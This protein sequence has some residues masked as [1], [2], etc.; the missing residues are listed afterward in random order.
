MVEERKQKPI[1]SERLVRRSP[2]EPAGISRPIT[3]RKTVV[4]EL[5][6]LLFGTRLPADRIWPHGHR[7]C[8]HLLLNTSLLE[9]PSC[10][11]FSEAVPSVGLSEPFPAM[12]GVRLRTLEAH[13][14][15]GTAVCDVAHRVPS[16]ISF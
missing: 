7:A 12:F 16:P 1:D 5:P 9:P 11:S 14:F 10:L 4:L 8:V 15:H 6:L 2:T 13:Q 3:G